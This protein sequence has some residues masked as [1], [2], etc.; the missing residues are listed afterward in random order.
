MGG[1]GERNY[2]ANRFAVRRESGPGTVCVCGTRRE[3]NNG[4]R[5]RQ[6]TL[7]R[8]QPSDVVLLPY[9]RVMHVGLD[10][11]HSTKAPKH[12]SMPFQHQP[13]EE[14]RRAKK[15]ERV[16]RGVHRG[17]HRATS[18]MAA[19][20]VPLVMLLALPGLTEFWC[21]LRARG[22]A[23]EETVGG[24]RELMVVLSRARRYVKNNA[25]G[26]VVKEQQDPAI[27]TA[28]LAMSFVL[29]SFANF[30]LLFRIIETHPVC[31]SLSLFRTEDAY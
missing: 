15:I 20:L 21:V 31:P 18:L 5:R 10:V 22:D 19:L 3:V 26:E 8:F 24:G 25:E 6:R 12:P 16:E 27:L 23:F 29:C 11:L 13:T 9:A 28:G 2:F 7:S 1:V 30:F 14:D 4:I 17:V